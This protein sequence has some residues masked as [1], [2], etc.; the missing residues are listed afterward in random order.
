MPQGGELLARVEELK[1]LM[2]GFVTPK[3]AARMIELL[4]EQGVTT[5]DGLI[6]MYNDVGPTQDEIDEREQPPGEYWAWAFPGKTSKEV[7]AEIR[8]QK[9]TD[10]ERAQA[11]REKEQDEEREEELC[12]RDRFEDLWA[13]AFYSS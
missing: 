6:S 2:G 12:G 9:M 5:W 3:E 8:G 13:L 1:D 7:M 4:E 10:E 11:E